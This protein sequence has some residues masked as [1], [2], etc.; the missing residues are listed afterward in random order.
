MTLFFLDFMINTASD[1]YIEWAHE[2][3]RT[4]DVYGVALKAD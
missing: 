3:V 1:L 2:I 4:A